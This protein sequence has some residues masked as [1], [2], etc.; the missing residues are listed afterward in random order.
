MKRNVVLFSIIF[1][2]SV[3]F[4]DLLLWGILAYYDYSWDWESRADLWQEDSILGW[5]N[6]PDMDKTVR[7]L[8]FKSHISTDSSGFRYSGEAENDTVILFL[9]DSFVQAAE[10]DNEDVFA[11]LLQKHTDYRIINAGVRGYGSCMEYLLLRRI[12]D[13]G[14]PLKKVYVF[15]Y[16]NDLRDII[17]TNLDTPYP[18]KPACAIEAD[19]LVFINVPVAEKHYSEPMSEKSSNSMGIKYKLSSI[20][21]HLLYQSASYNILTGYLQYTQAGKWLYSKNL[22][23]IPVFMSYDWNLITDDIL[24]RAIPAYKAICLKFKQL[25]EEN[26]FE[27]VFFLIPSE[28]QYD[29]QMKGHIEN[30]SKLYDFNPDYD[31]VYN[32]IHTFLLEN[33]MHCIYPLDEFNKQNNQRPITFRYDKHLNMYGHELLSKIIFEDMEKAVE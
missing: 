3:I 29:K 31:S 10:L 9:G 5:F 22:M 14:M 32:E 28:Y 1:I 16:I 13:S 12:A 23:E 24:E 2:I 25:A 11:Y 7:S 21:K 6:K 15:F 17:S 18:S 33:K 4:A 27:L 30:L 26:G 8:E 19:S 20:I